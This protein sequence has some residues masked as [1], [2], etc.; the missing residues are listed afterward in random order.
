MSPQRR[1][2]PSRHWCPTRCC[3]HAPPVNR[4]AS[5]CPGVTVSAGSADTWCQTPA[6]RA[7]S[8]FARPRHAARESPG[9]RETHVQP[10]AV[11]AAGSDLFQQPHTVPYAS[12]KGASLR[13]RRPCEGSSAGSD[14][15][16]PPSILAELQVWGRW[17]VGR[18]DDV[19]GV[20]VAGL[21]GTL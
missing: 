14:L 9:R 2:R 13:P 12:T 8:V 15:E 3:A 4:T 19:D 16:C 11:Q 10:A 17:S 18:V 20:A 7:R 5:R 1:T 21:A 6:T